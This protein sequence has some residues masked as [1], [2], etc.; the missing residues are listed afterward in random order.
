MEINASETQLKDFLNSRGYESRLKMSLKPQGDR[1][2]ISTASLNICTVKVLGERDYHFG[3][4][5]ES[6]YDKMVSLYHTQM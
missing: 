3:G 2:T 5:S 4:I 1:T 6:F